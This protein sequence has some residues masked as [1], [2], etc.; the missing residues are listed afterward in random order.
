MSKL[1]GDGKKAQFVIGTREIPYQID[2]FW[3]LVSG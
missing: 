3:P 2:E 1:H